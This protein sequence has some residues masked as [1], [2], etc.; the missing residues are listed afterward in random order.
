MKEPVSTE[1]L[2][3]HHRW[4]R[5]LFNQFF[6]GA[7][8]LFLVVGFV[9]SIVM[10]NPGIIIAGFLLAAFAIAILLLMH[11]ILF[12][13]ER[14]R[15]DRDAKEK[16]KCLDKEL[17]NRRVIGVCN[18]A[19]VQFMGFGLILFGLGAVFVEGL[20]TGLMSFAIGIALMGFGW[21]FIRWGSGRLNKGATEQKKFTN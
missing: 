8:V 12:D 13:V 18:G 5:R 9:A 20:L 15:H 16:H 1:E 3:N 10:A 4:L 11:V 14:R 7:A 17:A 19:L 2:L 21:C 6:I